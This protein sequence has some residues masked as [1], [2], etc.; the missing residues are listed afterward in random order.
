MRE[1]VFCDEIVAPGEVLELE[2][3]MLVPQPVDPSNPM[4]DRQRTAMQTSAPECQ[5][6]HRNI[7]PLGFA[8][9]KYD[10]LGRYSDLERIITPM[11]QLLAQLPVDDHTI[12]RIDHFDETTT[13]TGGVELSE[14]IA[15]SGKVERCFSKSVYWYAFKR[16]D[17]EEINGC[18]LENIRSSLIQGGFKEML[19]QVAL[20]E[21]FRTIRK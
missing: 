18:T 1:K 12:A 2:A 16:R 20:S 6:C 14:V 10:P 9:G 21:E 13:V 17:D 5:V 4:T 8:L 3:S 11:G 7:N 15:D 19:T